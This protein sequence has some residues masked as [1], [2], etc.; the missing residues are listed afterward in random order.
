MVAALDGIRGYGG[1]PVPSDVSHE[2]ADLDWLSF[3]GNV[4]R[5]C[6]RPSAS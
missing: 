4:L 6:G 5:S 1:G 2:Q 3:S